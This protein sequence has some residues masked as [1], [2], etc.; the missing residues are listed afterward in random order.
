M[1][2]WADGGLDRRLHC[3]QLDLS[4]VQESRHLG[5]VAFDVLGLISAGFSLVEVGWVLPK[6]RGF[7]MLGECWLLIDFAG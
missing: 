6:L 4:L 1:K 2:V 7:G 3:G 5:G